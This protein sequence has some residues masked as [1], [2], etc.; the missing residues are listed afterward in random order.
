MYPRQQ[1]QQQQQEQLETVT[2]LAV[3]PLSGHSAGAIH[4][5]PTL[6][7]AS[8]G[9]G[10]GEG[11]QGLESRVDPGRAVPSARR[12]FQPGARVA[13]AWPRSSAGMVSTIPY[14]DEHSSTGFP[15]SYVVYL[16]MYLTF[17]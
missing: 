9:G 2:P 17:V 6:P 15:A 8:R 13:R 11:G 1:Q 7:P 14:L 3:S 4:T 12:G 5:Q 16:Y 10:H